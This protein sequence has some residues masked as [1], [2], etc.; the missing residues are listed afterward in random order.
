MNKD[1][2]IKLYQS[3][4]EDNVEREMLRWHASSIAEC[5]R[6]QYYQRLGIKKI[7]EPA[8]AAMMLRWAAGHKLEEVIRPHIYKLYGIQTTS[9][10]RL[11]SDTY[12]LTGEYDNYV[13][14]VHKLVEIK[15]VSDRAFMQKDNEVYL[16]E[17]DGTVMRNGKEY[18][19]YKP[20][21]D[22]YLHHQLQQH[23]YELLL[24]ERGEVVEG[25]DYVY[26]SLGGR[27]VVY[28][29]KPDPKIRLQVVKRLQVLKEAWDKQ[30]P[31][32]CL[33]KEDH[34]LWGST[35]QYCGY[36]PKDGGECCS[37]DL[38]KVKE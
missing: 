35:M 31:P 2:S 26:I 22:P 25:I 15:S 28:S 17:A 1:L 14:D 7:A 33:C 9:N 19:N 10:V 16:K 30:E 37:L 13:F 4:S 24:K 27:I 18:V 21:E 32:Q 23:A 12:D 8:S 6:S 29:T 11:E 38:I 20:K 34:V 36:R 3:I 5:P